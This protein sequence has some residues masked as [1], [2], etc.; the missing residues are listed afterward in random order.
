MI[1]KFSY[2]D[3]KKKKIQKNSSLVIKNPLKTAQ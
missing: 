1:N 2:L 3:R